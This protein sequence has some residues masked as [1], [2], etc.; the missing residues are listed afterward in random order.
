MRISQAHFSLHAIFPTESEASDANAEVLSN[1]EFNSCLLVGKI[2]MSV[3]GIT[4]ADE[5]D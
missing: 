5:S 2:T 3:K 1:E 4:A